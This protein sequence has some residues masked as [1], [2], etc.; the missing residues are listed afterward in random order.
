MRLRDI[1]SL[2]GFVYDGHIILTIV[3]YPR[4]KL[5]V[6]HP[7][8]FIWRKNFV[9]AHRFI[10]CQGSKPTSGRSHTWEKDQ[11]S[12]RSVLSGLRSLRLS[13]LIILYIHPLKV[14]FCPDHQDS[15]LYI[16]FFRTHPSSIS[17]T[18]Y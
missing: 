9:E 3:T 6:P 14:I 7:Y 11:L 8:K 15:F 17:Y 16:T 12:Y 2:S 5:Q 13:A 1:R 10:L 4:I 18:L